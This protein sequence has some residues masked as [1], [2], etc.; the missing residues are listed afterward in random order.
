MHRLLVRLRFGAFLAV[1]GA[2][3]AHDA[4]P[5]DTGRP[6]DEVTEFVGFK[7]DTPPEGTMPDGWTKALTWRGIGPANMSG[8]ITAISVFE[9]DPTTYW[10]A[11]ASGGLVKTTDNGVTFEHQFDKEAT[12]SIGDVCVA[13]S[14]RNI[15][16]VGTG[17]NNPRNS[18][19][20]G[21]GVYKSTDGGKTWKNMGLTQ[22]FQIGR[23]VV[24][25][26]NPDIVYVGALGRLYGPNPER[27]LFK[28]TDGGKHWEKVLYHNDRTGVIDIAMNP[29]DPDTL[30][31]AMW[32]RKRDGFD[33]FVGP[34]V[35]KELD[36]YDPVE[37][38][39]EAAGIYKTTDGGKTFKK[40]QN[41]L[42]TCKFGRIGL[43][44]YR[45]DPKVVFAIVDCEK[46]GMGDAPKKVAQGDGF[47]GAQ[48]EDA[49]KA[50]AKVTMVLEGG[51]ADKAGLMVGDVIQMVD[52]K[53]VK[54][55]EDFLDAVR[56]R[57]ANDKLTLKV[58]RD[59]QT[60]EIEL[61]LGKRPDAAFGKK[62][63]FG[64]P[65]G[66][67]EG[68]PYHANYGG[69]KENVQDQQGPEGFQ[70]GGVYKSTDGGESWARVNSINPRPMYFSVVRVDPQDDK[71]V[72][73]LGIAQY[74]SSDGGKTFKNDA[75]KLVHADGHALW[76]DPRDG[77]HMLIGCDGGFYVTYDRAGHWDH[78]NHLA[79]GQF[80]HVAV[81]SKRPY[82]VYG[83]LQDNGCWGGPSIGLKGGVGPINEDWI[84]INGGDGYV[85][86]VD[87]IDPDQ[88]YAEAQNGAIVR[89][90]LKTGEV[91]PIRPKGMGKGFGE[92]GGGGGGKGEGGKGGGGK[93]GPQHRFNWNTPYILSSHNPKIFYCAAEVVFRSLDRG[94]DLKIISPEITLSKRGSATALA[95][96]PK[97]ADVLWV[98]TDDGALWVTRNGGKDWT[99]IKLP[100]SKGQNGNGGNGLPGPR[101]VAT[102]EASRKVEGRAYVAF[103]GHRSDDDKPYL[104]VTEDF[105]QTWKNITSNLPSFGST[106]CL[107]EDVDNPDLLYCGTEFGVFASLNRGE[108]W[109]RINNNLPTVAVHE[110]AV[111][112]TAG[113]IVAATHG[114]SLWIL[115]VSALRQMKADNLKAKAHLYKPNTAVRWQLEPAHGK[116]NRRFVGQN[117]P[118]GA[119][120]YYSLTEPAKKVSFEVKDIEGKSLAKWTASGKAGLNKTTWDMTR[121]FEPDPKAAKGN[122]GDKADMGEMEKQGGFGGGGGGK[123][124]FGGFGG[125]G[126]R[127]AGPGDYLVT[128]TVEGIELT[129]PMTTTV[130]LE[131]DPNLPPGRRPADEEEILPER[132]ID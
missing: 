43:D 124:G 52:K 76:I 31:V 97:N 84:S 41:G 3:A 69:Q 22:T 125:A 55:Y 19:S 1:A 72:Y 83:G 96:S 12:V 28:T 99:Q 56:D 113:E 37:K 88:I 120:I 81:C 11:T 47:V 42:P 110:V 127:F 94:N 91:A 90:H 40:L 112:P 32:E 45:K 85:C 46:I 86:R 54:V 16:W 63:G 10:V 17:E 128:M 6:A 102:I 13:P 108:S 44:Y 21:D 129:G 33:S 66:A 30:L 106:R 68:R 77:R 23:V 61:T 2:L 53:E 74:H 98:G 35:P 67:K 64:G 123:K 48:G 103:D 87:P 62:G 24:H 36:T 4:L 27:G 89:R 100:E 70:Y 58:Q 20:Y 8:R 116:T 71:H 57:N 65:G 38:W 51:P 121:P 49:E 92:G 111:H 14:D 93:G 34:D 122:K 59:D 131:S 132:I 29:A 75:G 105:G 82:W 78:L 104:Y 7:A 115:D 80:Y 26:K 126:R 5:A 119:H 25:P 39:G 50:G 117:P 9:A 101:W 60:K 79:L 114:R 118:A 18:V 15:V 107:R 130:R 109:T 95:E 73:V